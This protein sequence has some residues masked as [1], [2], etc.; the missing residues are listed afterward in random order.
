M[1]APLANEAGGLNYKLYVPSSYVGKSLP[2]LVM[3][4]GCTQSPD[5]FAA[6]TQN[7]QLGRRA[8]LSGCLPGANAVGQRLEMLELVQRRRSAA[9]P[10]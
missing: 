10:G 5:D 9:R 6:G 7:E 3:L 2:L 8:Y 1:N 4:H